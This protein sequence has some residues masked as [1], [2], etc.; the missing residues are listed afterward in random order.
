MNRLP[1]RSTRTDTLFPYT[2][3]FRADVDGDAHVARPARRV[4]ARLAQRPFAQLPDQIGFLGDRN[5]Q[6]G[7][8]HAAVAVGPAHPRLHPRHHVRFGMDDRLIAARHLAAGQGVAQI[9]LE[10][11]PLLRRLAQVARLET[12]THPPVAPA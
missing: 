1:P 9:V 2:T 3:L 4:L 5:E 6:R 12:D 7:R 8:Y 10:R 11:A